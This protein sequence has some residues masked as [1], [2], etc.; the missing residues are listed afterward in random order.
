MAKRKLCAVVYHFSKPQRDGSFGVV[1]FDKKKTWRPTKKENEEIGEIC[2][3][4]CDL[5][6]DGTFP[7]GASATVVPDWMPDEASKNI[8]REALLEEGAAGNRYTVG[9][10]PSDFVH[11]QHGTV[12]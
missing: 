8:D 11:D 5:V 3:Q 9:L 12:Q 6:D 4:F 2:E 7:P 10:F 1:V